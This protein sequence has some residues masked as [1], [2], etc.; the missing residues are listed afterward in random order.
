MA[1]QAPE[2]GAGV[3]GERLQELVLVHQEQQRVVGPTKIKGCTGDT[4][5]AG[6][7]ANPKVGYRISDNGRIS[8][9][10]PYLVA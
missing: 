4:V 10:I 9:R 3:G 1:H 2:G 5:F 6:Y 7:P 8:G